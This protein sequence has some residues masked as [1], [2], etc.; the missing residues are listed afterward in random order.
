MKSR[1]VNLRMTRGEA[2]PFVFPITDL[3][4]Q[5]AE[6]DDVTATWEAKLRETD[7][8][9]LISKT[10]TDGISIV[11]SDV[12]VQLEEDDTADMA[13]RVLVWELELRDATDRPQ[14]PSRGILTIERDI[15]RDA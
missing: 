4:G 5:A 3:D 13:H 2:V 11:G 15:V 6:L 12:I 7:V 9:P 14:N 1:T 8:L 10:T